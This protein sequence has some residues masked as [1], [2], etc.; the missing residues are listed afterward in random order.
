MS[1]SELRVPYSV[2]AR[3][4]LAR[5]VKQFQSRETYDNRASL[6]KPVTL[7]FSDCSGD[8]RAARP[9]L[10]ERAVFDREILLL[11]DRSREIVVKVETLF[12]RQSRETDV[13]YSPR[14]DVAR[15]PFKDRFTGLR[16]GREKF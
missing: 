4:V 16:R 3:S 2:V 8:E 9:T 14:L 11:L 5:P 7:F 13:A 6:V 10:L 12:R 15:E 1:K